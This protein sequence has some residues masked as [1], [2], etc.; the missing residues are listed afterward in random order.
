M[1]GALSNPLLLECLRSSA[2]HALLPRSSSDLVSLLSLL[3]CWSILSGLLCMVLL[4]ELGLRLMA[5][6]SV[7]NDGLI[8]ISSIGLL[9]LSSLVFLFGS[10]LNHLHIKYGLTARAHP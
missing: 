7:F 6:A 9:P 2:H 3:Y 4:R 5:I 1:P 10:F 8:A